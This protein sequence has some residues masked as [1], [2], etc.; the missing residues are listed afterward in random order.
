VQREF[1][2]RVRRNT[3]RGSAPAAL[4]AKIHAPA[5]SELRKPK[6]SRK[7]PGVGVNVLQQIVGSQRAEAMPSPPI[8]GPPTPAPLPAPPLAPSQ[9]MAMMQPMQ[10]MQPGGPLTTPPPGTPMQ[11]MP[12]VPPHLQP[13]QY[14]QP[15]YGYAQPTPGALYQFQ[16]VQ[17]PMSPTGQLRLFEADELPPQYRMSRSVPP[18]LKVGLAGALAVSVAA[19]V[20]F[21]IVRA[22]QSSEPPVVATVHIDSVPHGADVYFDGAHLQGTTPLAVPNTPAGKTIEIRVE[23]AHHKAFTESFAVPA[24]G[25]DVPFMADLKPLTGKLVI[26][27]KPDGADVKIDGVLRGRTPVTI[28]DVDLDKAKV[29]ELRL[30]DYQPFVQPLKWPASGEIDI[31]AKLEH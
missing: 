1:G 21:F 16:S 27:S 3:A 6:P 26:V 31:D 18:W 9:Q 25:G 24:Q 4:A 13:Y 30:K 5:V 23:L 10:P 28:N 20:T 14:Q 15:P 7:T 19:A 12:G 17:P 22:M 8:G 29:V 2:S 11:V